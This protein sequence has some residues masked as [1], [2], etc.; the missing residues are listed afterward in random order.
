MSALRKGTQEGGWRD[1]GPEI[2]ANLDPESRVP[3]SEEKVRGYV[4]AVPEILDDG[5]EP[6]FAI[7]LPV[8]DE[9]PGHRYRGG[10]EIRSGGEPATLVELGVG[11]KIY[12]GH[13]PFDA[14]VPYHDSA[15][16]KPPPETDGSSHDDSDMLTPG[17]GRYL[18]D[19]RLRRGQKKALGEHVHASVPGHGEFRE[20][21]QRGSSRLS[22][23]YE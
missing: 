12:L 2:L 22:L 5:L 20:D 3:D 6:L 21:N 19:G 10:Q 13:Y 16:I 11:W 17:V 15:V 4:A 18:T 8:I 9:P 14:S 7:V 23:V 1:R